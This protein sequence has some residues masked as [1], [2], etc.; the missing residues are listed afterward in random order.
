[1][2]K[3]L[4]CILMVIPWLIG[5]LMYG[6]VTVIWEKFHPDDIIIPGLCYPSFIDSFLFSFVG[7]VLDFISP[8][9]IATMLNLF[10]YINIR[11]RGQ[12]LAATGGGNNDFRLKQ[13]RR[14]ARSLALLTLVYG[15]TWIPYVTSAVG[16]SLGFQISPFAF[17]VTCFLMV[18][19]SAVN[20]LIYPVMQRRFRKTFLDIWKRVCKCPNNRV[21]DASSGIPPNNEVIVL[22]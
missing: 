22:Q 2:T 20:P 16:R 9:F 4:A 6:P 8:Y 7:S 1:M 10:L 13:D 5:F 18:L 14:T 3:R 19:N 17:D 15:T 12:R 11:K 21:A